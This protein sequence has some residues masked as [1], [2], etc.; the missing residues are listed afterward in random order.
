MKLLAVILLVSTSFYARADL[1]LVQNGKVY[2]VALDQAPYTRKIATPTK[3]D[4][5]KTQFLV[6]NGGDSAAVRIQKIS[7]TSMTKKPV[8]AEFKPGEGCG[9]NPME[10]WLKNARHVAGVE[11]GPEVFAIQVPDGFKEV[12]KAEVAMPLAQGCMHLRTK[13]LFRNKKIDLAFALCDD[14][15]NDVAQ[16][17]RTPRGKE[18]QWEDVA[19]LTMSDN[20]P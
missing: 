15:A 14:G 12:E 7:L 17:M 9:K 6:V 4:L 18:P 8:K 3:D 20:C 13:K 5:K 10:G 2:A 1:F 19:I 16:I 11:Y